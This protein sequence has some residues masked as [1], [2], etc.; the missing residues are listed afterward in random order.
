MKDG[1][2][3]LK[4]K[5][6]DALMEHITRI[7]Y[8]EAVG[9][10]D[11]MTATLRLPQSDPKTL[12]KLISSLQPGL[13]F[14]IS[15]IDEDGKDVK[16]VKREGD[17]IAVHF[18]SIEGVSTATLV[19]VNYLHRLRSEHITQIW[20]D[21]HDKIVKTIAGR[22][23]PSL[24][25]KVHGVKGTPAFTFQQNETDALFLMRLARENNYYCRVIGKE[26][27]FGRR[28]MVSGSLNLDY[29]K[30]GL[31]IRLQANLKDHLN[32]AHVYWGD[33]EKD[34]SKL[35]K[36]T[37]KKPPKATNSGGKLGC[38]LGKKAFGE[39]SVTI[40]GYDFPLYNN[41]SQAEAKG[42]SEVDSAALDF[43]EGV[44]NCRNA[45]K[46]MCG[47]TLKVKNAGW[48]YDGAFVI[49]K[50]FHEYSFNGLKTEITFKANSLPK[51]P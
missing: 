33:P 1:S 9:E 19:G 15:V 38:D 32:A 40:G 49:T 27:H 16:G 22:S 31:D 41:Q 50:V 25:A 44:V 6:K 43:I 3:V 8:T 46:A 11:G 48:P 23:K 21:G 51:E 45:Q 18:E 7:T 5:G 34:G 14:E 17:I 30:Q 26:L 20:E 39:K 47:A 24:T 12:K 29:A 35:K 4:V 2:L 42:Q 37:Y 10:L 36:A 28:D 13:P